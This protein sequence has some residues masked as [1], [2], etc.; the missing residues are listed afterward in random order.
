MTKNISRRKFIK[1]F[2]LGLT[3]MTLLDLFHIKRLHAKS[4]PKIV[5]L[6]TGIGGASCLHYLNEI[7]NLVDITV[8]D[9]NNKIRTGPF[10]NLVIGD[11]L[12]EKDITFSVNKNRYQNINFIN[13]EVDYINSENKYVK[14]SNDLKVNFDFLIISPGISYKDNIINGV[15][16]FDKSYVPHC[17]DGDSDISNFK[18]K[19]NDLENNS[20]IIITSPDYPYRCP[21]APYERASLIAN[22]F[23]K[24]K[25]EC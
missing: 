14:I 21:P 25:N 7:S 9:K 8:I 4:K 1:K 6:G 22:Y 13:K 23:K 17:W 11:L 10:S 20:K 2:L 3:Y 16:R 19:L 18:K 24:K 12:S 5:I 15:N